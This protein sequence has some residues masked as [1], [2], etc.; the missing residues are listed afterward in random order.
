MLSG[1]KIKSILKYLVLFS[2]ISAT[3]MI[4]FDND[5]SSLKILIPL[6]ISLFIINY[7]R[8]Y[9]LYPRNKPASYA[10]ASIILETLLILV[11]GTFDK[12]GVHILFFYV[13]VSSMVLMYPFKYSVLAASTFIVA[14]YSLS[15]VTKELSY[16]SML[17]MVVSLVVSSVFVIGM[18]HLVKMQI[19]E[20][21]KQARINSELEQAYKMLIDNSAAVQKL[22][23]EEERTRMARE[24]HDTLA[25]TLTSL[26]V[27]LE[28]CKKLAGADPSRLPGELEKAQELS[29]SGFNDIK[30][31]IKALRPKVM[32]D[33]SLLASVTTITNEVMENTGVNI[34][35]NSS[36]PLELELS[37]AME[38]A[39]FRAIQ[40]S[41]TNSIRHGHA[42]DI[43]VRITQLNGSIEV[44]VEDNG[45]GCTNIKA[46]Y[47]LK[48]IRERINALNGRAEF[49]S[50]SQNGFKTIINIPIGN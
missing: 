23:I 16:S 25:H 30:R 11:I 49:T 18:S 1:L 36:L 20:K 24:I 48:G 42:T 31:S 33:K 17:S 39:I 7:S 3:A 5:F 35:V 12:S 27:Q 6:I 13:M 14:E 10:A 45:L 37:T 38:V 28:A 22:A 32:E 26:I 40:E 50:S 34:T 15:T 46:G 9:W 4:M 41:I 8:E 43:I 29:R 21:E 19:H 2:Y 44:I 47:G